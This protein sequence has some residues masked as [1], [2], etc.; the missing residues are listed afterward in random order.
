MT[1]HFH[2]YQGTAND[3]VMVDDRARTFPADDHALV[4]RL[5]DRRRG[6]GADGL[7]LLRILP[8]YDFEMVYFNADGH[9]GS[10]CGNGGRCTVAFAR[11]LG[12]ITDKAHFLAADGPHEASVD[13]DGRVHLRMMDV[14]GQ[15]ELPDGIFLNTGSPHIVRFLAASTLAEYDV[16]GEG[17]A[18][19]YGDTFRERGGTNVNFVEAPQA[20]DQPWQVRTYERGVEDET[21]SCG[22]GVTA[23]ALA[24]ARR[25]AASPVPLRTLGGDLSVA[26]QRHADGSFTDVYLS[27]PAEHVFAGS[28]AL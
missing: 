16:Y 13:A 26:F 19:R 4:R 24:A 1:L 20:A 23:V 7:I 25:G 18:V 22:T 21:F 9:L 8:G 3:F 5:C 17:R 12:V 11:Q 10:M 15:Q 28:I 2:K 6:I 27:G 14:A